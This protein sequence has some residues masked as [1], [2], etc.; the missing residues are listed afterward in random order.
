MGVYHF[1]IYKSNKKADLSIVLLVFLVLITAMFSLFIFTTKS[2]SINVKISNI[3]I[4]NK[5]YEK[6]NLAKFYVKE[7]AMES[8]IKSYKE[9]SFNGEFV[10]EPTFDLEKN[11][12]F[13]KLRNNLNED[14]GKKFNEN[15]KKKIGSYTFDE[16][17]LNKIKA[18]V[19]QDKFSYFFDGEK[20]SLNIS[21][22]NIKESS[23]D[24][25]IS[26]DFN[27]SFVFILE[28]LGLESYDKIYQIKEICKTK[29]TIP[30]IEDCF[31]SNLKNFEVT[32]VEKKGFDNQKY[33]VVNL[34]TKK[35][36]LIDEIFE[37]IKLNFIPV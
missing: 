8:I 26:F 6:E 17:Y 27:L 2:Q 30:S 20:L 35:S 32:V 31:R 11:V 23:K 25:N 1:S 19:S 34:T 4:T 28:D 37:N 13:T 22:L 14:F 15:F 18:Q 24:M 16:D 33:F 9:I 7:V 29:L 12:R 5:I 21:N 3:G 10:D 36:F